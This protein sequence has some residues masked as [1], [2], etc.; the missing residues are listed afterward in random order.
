[1]VGAG[2]CALSPSLLF[3][4]PRGIIR[5]YLRTIVRWEDP[6]TRST[7]ELPLLAHNFAPLTNGDCDPRQ[8]RECGGTKY[9]DA[10]VV[11]DTTRASNAMAIVQTG[12][13]LVYEGDFRNARQLLAALGRRV[14]KHLTPTPDDVLRRA[15]SAKDQWDCHR[16][17]VIEKA[18]TANM[19]LMR[20]DHLLGLSPFY[21][22]SLRGPIVEA[23]EDAFRKQNAPY[24]L[25]L[26]QILGTNGS[27]QWKK[28][29]VFV[30]QLGERI[31]PH[32]GVFAPIRSEYLDLFSRVEVPL[33]LTMEGG[34]LMDVGV[35]T[36]I[37]TAIILS[38]HRNMN[39]ICIDNNSRAVEC[40]KDNFSK[41]GLSN[42]TEVIESDIFPRT[43]S[44]NAAGK[45][46]IIVCNP[47]WIPGLAHSPLDSAIYD[48]G[49]S[50]LRR[51][52][53]GVGKHLS[54]HKDAEIWLVISDLAERLELRAWE[55]VEE[56]LKDGGLR[57]E[58][59]P[60]RTVARHP[61]AKGAK[62]DA[63]GL[64]FPA[65]AKARAKERTSL[66]RLRRS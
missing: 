36:G 9:L 17:I 52:L 4:S 25:P 59:S 33:S 55:E 7:Q 2:I 53:L 26:R 22:R 1:M 8:S 49:S 56:M 58:G 6:S 61:K 20:V 54:D 37:I 5:R 66:Y 29:G 62:N 44:S 14:D 42:R 11:D 13:A 34:R 16:R 24:L 10:V 21:K 15:P 57:V 12:R 51:F 38:R 28:N 23:L 43:S 39:A 18:R 31:Y 40:A 19:L 64:P 46:D 50:F 3:L 65:V 41:L 35:G 63:F 30:S 60:H 47:P 48:Q 27:Y 45:A 32:F